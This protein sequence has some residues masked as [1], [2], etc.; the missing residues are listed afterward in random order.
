[1]TFRG[2]SF[3]LGN[4][5]PSDIFGNKASHVLFIPG[6]CGSSGSTADY[7]QKNPRTDLRFFANTSTG[8][9]QVTNA[10]LDALIATRS[11]TRFSAVLQKASKAIDS[12]GGDINTIK[13]WS[14]GEA[15][16]AYVN[17]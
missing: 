16:L 4:S 2:H 10:I 3:S 15:L 17:Q 13:A 7:I 12:N 6:S 11:K 9:G 5:F 8:K 14:N 1:M